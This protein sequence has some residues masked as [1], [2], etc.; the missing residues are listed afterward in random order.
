MR[1]GAAPGASLAMM[2]KAMK[3][4]IRGISTMPKTLVQ[5]KVIARLGANSAA[6]AVPESDAAAM[7]AVGFGLLVLARRRAHAR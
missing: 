6:S 4:M 2:Q 1:A 3:T 5:P 7:V